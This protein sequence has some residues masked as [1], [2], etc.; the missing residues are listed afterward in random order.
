MWW[1]FV[2]RTKEELTDAWRAW[3]NHDTDRFG[4][5][6]SRLARIEAPPPPWLRE[7]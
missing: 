7:D 2:G 1:N 5:V 3:Q 6:P 4:P